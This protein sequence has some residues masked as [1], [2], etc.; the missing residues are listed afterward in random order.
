MRRLLARGIVGLEGAIALAALG[1]AVRGPAPDDSLVRDVA[2]GAIVVGI[3]LA[4]AW[5]HSEL[6]LEGA[7][8]GD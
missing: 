2:A 4:V 1:A 6:E 5:A 8:D 7:P 3:V